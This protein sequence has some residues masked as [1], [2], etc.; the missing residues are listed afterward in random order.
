[1]S[2][3]KFSSSLSFSFFSSLLSK[4]SPSLS[5]SLFSS[6][7]SSHSRTRQDL[8]YVD[9]KIKPFF[10]PHLYPHP[11]YHHYSQNSPHHYPYHSSH[12][13]PQY[14]K[15]NLSSYSLH[16]LGNHAYMSHGTWVTS[17]RANFIIVLFPHFFGEGCT[18]F[19]VITWNDNIVSFIG[20]CCKRDLKFYRA[21]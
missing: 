18:D 6:L 8:Q 20:L 10:H 13:D 5:L 7:S 15:R 14:I 2:F 16:F 21:Y 11:W 17:L 9:L 19:T 12:H 4:F 3:S 1:M